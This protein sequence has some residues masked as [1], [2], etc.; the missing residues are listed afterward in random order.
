MDGTP[1]I[2]FECGQDSRVDSGRL[3]RL[4]DGRPCPTCSERLMASLRPLLPGWDAEPENADA[5]LP[6]LGADYAPDFGP[7]AEPA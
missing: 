1:A 3:N 2:C 7:D 5:Q 4:D 6:G